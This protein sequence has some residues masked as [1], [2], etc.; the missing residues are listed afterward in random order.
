MELQKVLSWRSFRDGYLS[1]L[2]SAVRLLKLF[3]DAFVNQ[4]CLMKR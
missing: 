4:A 1:F 2:Y 3:C